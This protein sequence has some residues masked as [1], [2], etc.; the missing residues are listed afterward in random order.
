LAWQEAF[1]FSSSICQADVNGSGDDADSDDLDYLIAYM[2]SG[3]P[4]PVP[5]E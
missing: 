4:P 5:C 2:F 1:D 3:G